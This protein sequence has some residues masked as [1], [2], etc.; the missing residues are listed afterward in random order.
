MSCG[1]SRSF[2]W[3]INFRKS[4]LIWRAFNHQSHD[5]RIMGGSFLSRDFRIR[6]S[7]ENT[8]WNWIL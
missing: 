2:P 8:Q 4:C 1:R 6:V 3:A 5:A 7:K